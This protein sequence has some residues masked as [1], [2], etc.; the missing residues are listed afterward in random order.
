MFD[1]SKREFLMASGS[2]ML[3]SSCSVFG[4]NVKMQNQDHEGLKALEKA[5]GGRLGVCILDTSTGNLVGHRIN[6]RF[7]MCSTFKFALA[8]IMLK[9]I[10]IGKTTPEFEI[11][12][13]KRGL[14]PYADS[15]EVALKTGKI[16][17][18]DAIIA[19]QKN[20]DNISANGLLAYLG[21]PQAMTQKLREL[22]DETTRLD[23]IE[24][25]MN[26]VAG[27]GVH[28]T[29]TPIA[30]AKTMQKILLGDYMSTENRKYLLDL[31]IATQTGK[32]RLRAGL[33]PE[34]IAGDKTGTGVDDSERKIPNKYNDVAIVYA[35]NKAPHIITSYYEADGVYDE[36]RDQDQKVL[37]EVGRIAAKFIE[38]GK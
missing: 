18:K 23:R 19:I 4:K 24:P 27:D 25:E 15:V 38:N 10:E 32:K 35:P 33:R 28:D 7:G 21:G 26:L 3:L 17:V 13:E 16:S 29:T 2:A 20:S 14:K 8:A 1:F 12:I 22:G 9:E 30:F 6:E 34:W 36:I 11:A 31:M 37:E 5:N